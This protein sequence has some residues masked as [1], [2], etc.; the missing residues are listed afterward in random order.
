[1]N[2]SSA[3]NR[4][5]DIITAAVMGNEFLADT[6]IAAIHERYWL[7]QRPTPDRPDRIVRKAESMRTLHYMHY[8]GCGVTDPLPWSKLTD[9]QKVP[10]ILRAAA[11]EAEVQQ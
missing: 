2:D 1:M 6:I 9:A 11:D 4:L 3:D 5:R 10:W 8:I 7:I